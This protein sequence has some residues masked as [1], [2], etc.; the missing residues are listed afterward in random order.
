MPE[1]PEVETIRRSLEKAIVGKR[2]V[3]VE[4][5]F[6][7]QFPDNPKEVIGKKIL[8]I[9]RRGKVLII[10]LS[11]QKS[12]LVH[13]KLSGQLIWAA[14]AGD[15][16]AAEH[17]I[18]FLG[19]RKLPG[20][21][22][23]VIISINGGKLFF[24]EI[25]KFGWIKVVKFNQLDQLVKLGKEPFD[26]DFTE[27]YLRQVFS[28]TAK[29]IKLVLMDQEKIAGI[30]NIY[31]NDA[32][33]EAK[34]HPERSANKLTGQQVAALKKAIILVLQ[35]GLKAGGSSEI[36]YVKPDGT[37]GSYQERFRV[38]RRD[39]QKCRKC[40]TLIKRIKLNGRGTFYCPKCQK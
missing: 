4:V 38:Y 14:K 16:T 9:E 24:N 20:K 23:R 18:P 39:G 8:G 25:R 27:D 31:A 5:F 26:E 22:T 2:I 13:L 40:G 15:K 34:V 36:Y 7:K 19:G 28:K 33:F 12:L 37:R 30:G 3:G 10:N 6:K 21:S 32:L 11:G 35:D 1:L 29:P 17:P